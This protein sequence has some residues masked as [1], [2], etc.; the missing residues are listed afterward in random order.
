MIRRDV[1]PVLKSAGFTKDGSLHYVLE[2]W[3]SDVYLATIGTSG[4]VEHTSKVATKA[5]QHGT[6]QWSPDGPYLVYARAAGNGD[7][8]MVVRNSETGIESS[9]TLTVTPFHFRTLKWAPDGRAVLTQGREAGYRGPKLDSQGLYRIDIE[10]GEATPLVQVSDL[11]PPDCVEW[12][13]WSPTGEVIFVRHG[14]PAGTPRRVVARDLQSGT[15]RELYR[16][17]RG[18]EIHHLAVSPDGE[19]LAV[20]WWDYNVGERAGVKVM[21]TSGQ[22]V[23]DLLS[24]PGLADFWMP[25]FAMAWAPD[26]RHLIYAPTRRGDKRI[27]IKRVSIDGG[28]PEDLGLALEG[29]WPYGLS[30]HPDGL[31]IA[32]TA[33]SSPQ[34]ELWVMENFLP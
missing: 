31:R 14:N 13:V 20:A 21:S 26:S 3:E 15:E 30:V 17:V 7:F 22:D 4:K 24:L 19:R 34:E 10:T 23:R 12:P 2:G 33:G 32:F 18:E 1:G 8:E 5:A 27:E 16:S 25:L 11:C 29:V 28:P 9:H 6:V